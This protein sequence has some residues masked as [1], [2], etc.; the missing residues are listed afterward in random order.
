MK[1][2]KG[3]KFMRKP[4]GQRMRSHRDKTSKDD[5]EQLD[6]FLGRMDSKWV[7][8]P[9]LTEDAC[10]VQRALEDKI[11]MLSKLVVTIMERQ[12]ASLTL[13]SKI[14]VPLKYGLSNASQSPKTHE[15]LAD[16]LWK[17]NRKSFLKVTS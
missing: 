4:R 11:C 3:K 6:F 1:M 9:A 10:E 14:L 16:E 8:K 17:S 13:L 2:V 12:Q 7:L 5:E 15:Q